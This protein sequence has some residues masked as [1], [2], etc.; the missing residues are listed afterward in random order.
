M[1][2]VSVYAHFRVCA[3]GASDPRDC[4]FLRTVFIAWANNRSLSLRLLSVAR[5]RRRRGQS[6]SPL[7]LLTLPKTT[8]QA[9][10]VMLF[11]G[12]PAPWIAHQG[13]HFRSKAEKAKEMHPE[14]LINK[15]GETCLA[16][17][18]YIFWLIVVRSTINNDTAFCFHWTYPCA[19]PFVAWDISWDQ[20]REI[21]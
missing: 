18:G 11:L 14:F 9:S 5:T 13:G 21:K 2:L 17:C 3:L 16:A 20:Y 7:S 15:A 6:R 4:L 10:K 1:L 12:N 8:V 19:I